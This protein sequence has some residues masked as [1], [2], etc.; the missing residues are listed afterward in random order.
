V[1]LPAGVTTANLTVGAPVSFSGFPIR[2]SVQ[3][4][5]SAFLVHSATGIPLVNLIEETA[6]LESVVGQFTLPHT[7][8]AGFQDENGNAYTNWYYTATINYSTD[9]GPVGKPLT[10]VFQLPSGQTIVDLDLL[11]GGAPAMAY[12]APVATVTSVAG[13]TG[14]ITGSQIISAPEVQTEL[15]ATFVP[16]FADTGITYNGDGTV[17]TVTESGITTSYTYNG[18][19]T[20]ATDTRL[21]VTRTYTYTDG[22]LTGIEAA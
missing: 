5:P 4:V 12:S 3:I 1:A 6:T 18:D 14:A 19:G 13:L 21:G 8:Q 20:V 17:A 15:S 10:K 16:A 7:D 11:P 2:S 22:N 9:R